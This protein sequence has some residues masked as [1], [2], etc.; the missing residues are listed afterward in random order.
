MKLSRLEH[1]G[2]PSERGMSGHTASCSIILLG[3]ASAYDRGMGFKD[4]DI[5][6]KRR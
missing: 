6:C 1:S 4:T 3:T 5:A 2:E